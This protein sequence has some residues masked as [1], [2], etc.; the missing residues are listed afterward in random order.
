MAKNNT[1]VM[2]QLPYLP[3]MAPYDFSLFPKLKRTMFWDHRAD[4]I[5]SPCELKGILK[6]KLNECFT[7]WKGHW[8]KWFVTE[9][10][11]FARNETNFDQK[12]IYF[13][14]Q[15]KILFIFYHTLYIHICMYV[16]VYDHIHTHIIL[17]VY[18]VSISSVFIFICVNSFI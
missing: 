16:C 1:T 9:G 2:K 7:D 6:W 11:Y 8:H 12:I 17:K 14:K 13:I 3:D 15:I 4:T 10:D 5:K 18:Y